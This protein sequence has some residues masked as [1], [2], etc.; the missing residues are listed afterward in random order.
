MRTRQDRSGMTLVELL[1]VIT[2]IIFL[3]GLTAL[4]FPRYQ[5]R[6]LVSRAADQ[7]QGTLV[8][9]RQM[10]LR[11]RVPTG[12]RL[13]QNGTVVNRLQYIQQPVDSGL[14]RFVGCNDEVTTP[15]FQAARAW[16][17]L[18]TSKRFGNDPNNTNH[19]LAEAG[20]YLEIYGTGIVHRITNVPTGGSGN[21][22]DLAQGTMTLP[23]PNPPPSP[24]PAYNNE[25]VNYRI[26]R[27]PIPLVGE[28]DILLPEPVIIDC[29]SGASANLTVVS[30]Q[31]YFDIVF[32]PSGGL[33]GRSTGNAM[34]ILWVRDGTNGSDKNAGHPTLIT[35]QPRTGA[36]AA[37]PVAP[38]SDPYL[39]AMDARSSGM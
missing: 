4:Y 33:I 39:F 7:L 6:E 8:M 22:L 35:I 26:I 11:D 30:G 9:A 2:I 3:M 23:G 15:A 5:D 29:S 16:F 32:A 21:V 1:V 28:Q 36:V 27:Q 19:I 14:G 31:T 38:G 17:S 24:I 37:H 20:D 10:A 13:Y 34:A 18:P 25:P 12:V